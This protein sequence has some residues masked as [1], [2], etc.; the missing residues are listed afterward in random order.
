MYVPVVR[1][2]IFWLISSIKPVTYSSQIDDFNFV[3]YNG[4][5]PYWKYVFFWSIIII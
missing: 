2:L 3:F 5:F 1:F 4:L